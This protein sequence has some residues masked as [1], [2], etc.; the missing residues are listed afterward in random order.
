MP[1][2]ILSLDGGATWALVQA[3]V[4][5]DIYGDIRGHMVLRE[6][7]MVIAN[8]GGSVL[9][10]LLCND[11]LLSD[12]IFFYNTPS[13][14]KKIFPPL[15]PFERFLPNVFRLL[16]KVGPKYSSSRKFQRLRKIFIEHDEVYKS[17]VVTTHIVDT[18]LNELPAVIKKLG[19]TYNGRNLQL[20]ISGFDYFRQRASFFRSNVLS[21]TDSFSGKY[22]QMTLGEA[23]HAS[24]NA[25]ISYYDRP[26]EVK[27]ELLTNE[28]SKKDRH[29]SWFWDGAVAGFNNPVLAGLVEAV[30]NNTDKISMED[31]RVL[32]LGTG[33]KRKA[34]IVDDET[35]NNKLIRDNYQQ[36]LGRPF[37]EDKRSFNFFNDIKKISKSILS[38][39]PDSATFIAYSFLNP[40]L[41]NRKSTLIRISPWIVPENEDGIYCYPPVYNKD[42]K[43]RD[44][45][46]KLMN[47]DFDVFEG[48]DIKM[49]DMMCDRFI[50][51]DEKAIFLQN[52]LIR[53]E[54]NK[55][56][57]Y[58]G[59]HS[60]RE[61]KKRWIELN[62][63]NSI[64]NSNNTHINNK[65][66]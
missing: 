43:E 2:K 7:D 65:T 49:I 34:I 57:G 10:G 21:K 52:Q 60:Y 40:S 25:P 55:T 18:Y 37:V 63:D 15:F 29:K 53:G 47:L 3:R 31:F 32:S 35:S 27:L 14:V 19:K 11:M 23:I 42:Q 22:Y 44:A 5:K 6:F 38:D 26:A 58:L 1:F 66:L 39:P 16:F 8:S 54:Y 56:N 9:L 41:D 36:N 30:T 13:Q 20:I 33:Q 46:I 4:L 50:V 45:F 59:Y 62:A 17:G 64:I 12:I 51:N 61:A 24:T 48:R 28:I